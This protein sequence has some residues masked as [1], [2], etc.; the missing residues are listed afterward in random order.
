[1]RLCLVALVLV[2]AAFARGGETR[3]SLIEQTV[4]TLKEMKRLLA[5]I[6]DRQTAEV[7]RPKLL[8]LG[9]RLK[10]LEE[11]QRRVADLEEKHRREA[12]KII[13]DLGREVKRLGKVASASQV[14]ADVPVVSIFDIDF[15]RRER[16]KVDVRNLTLAVDA[17]AL[18]NGAYP[19][20]LETLTESQPG[21]GKPYLEKKA[22]IDPWG[23]VYNY[24]P[25]QRH[26]TTRQPLIYSMGAPGKGPIIRNWSVPKK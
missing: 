13:S 15:N 4:A 7:A 8:E 6:K 26:P 24:D 17:Y 2:S 1:M 3:E 22:L 25:A 11:Q 12:E 10:K 9:K 20:T 23:Y 16:A 18:R 5:G 21:G 19:P 14:L